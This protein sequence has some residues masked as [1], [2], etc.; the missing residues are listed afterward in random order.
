MSSHFNVHHAPFFL[1]HNY[2]VYHCGVP[3]E[4]L[5]GDAFF[6][7]FSVEKVKTLVGAAFFFVLNASVCDLASLKTHNSQRAERFLFYWQVSGDI[8]LW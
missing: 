3:A 5:Q 4:V 8:R 6:L 1:S 7:G 2:S